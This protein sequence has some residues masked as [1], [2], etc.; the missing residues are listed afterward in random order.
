MVRVRIRWAAPIA[1]IVVATGAAA[2]VADLGDTF[3][4]PQTPAPPG[5]S[6]HVFAEI[7]GVR[8]DATTKGFEH[9]IPVVAVDY[10]LR[11]VDTTCDG[12]HF[13]APVG[14]A[15][16][17]LDELVHRGP[18]TGRRATFTLVGST[19]GRP[20]RELTLTLGDARIVSVHTVLTG[21]LGN[22]PSTAVGSYEDVTLEPLKGS[23]IATQA[24]GA[25]K[26]DITC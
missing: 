25:I 16:P 4:Q 5:Q 23:Q 10:G 3:T 19:S 9:Q 15:T 22:Q 13:R 14:E 2:A 12:V 24:S 7:E 11:K 21:G 8:G 1:A 20:T 17:A 6:T 18:T 26:S